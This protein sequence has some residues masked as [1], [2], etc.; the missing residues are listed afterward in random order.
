MILPAG[1]FIP[2]IVCDEEAASLCPCLPAEAP[3]SGCSSRQ[4]TVEV[5]LIPVVKPQ[6]RPCRPYTVNIEVTEQPVVFSQVAFK[7]FFAGEAVTQLPVPCH[8]ENHQVAGAYPFQVLSV[9]HAFIK[10][11]QIMQPPSGEHESESLLPFTP[12]QICMDVVGH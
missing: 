11:L 7:R 2:R 12:V 6:T 8:L 3:E 1:T 5:P 10:S 9:V 4:V